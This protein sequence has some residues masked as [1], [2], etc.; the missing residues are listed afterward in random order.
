MPY[1]QLLGWPMDDGTGRRMGGGWV[2]G[3]GSNM[4][5]VCITMYHLG[6]LPSEDNKDDVGCRS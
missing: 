1:F 2:D 6:F 5:D 4:E 3:T